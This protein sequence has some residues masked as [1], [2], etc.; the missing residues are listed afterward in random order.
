M[1]AKGNRIAII[2]G[3]RTPFLRAGTGFNDMMGWELGRHAV[4]GLVAKTGI[5]GNNVGHVIFGTVAVDVATTNVAREILLGAGLPDSIP[6]HTCTVAC[7]SA[8]MAI[9]SGI[10]LIETGQVDS[11]IAGGVEFMSDLDIRISKKY[12]RFI[13][14]MTLFKRPK[15]LGGK[16]KLLKKMRPSDFIVPQRPA[17]NEFATNHSMGDNAE[18][19]AK[20][21]GI[22]REQQDEYAAMSHQRSARAIEEGALRHEVTPV[23][24]PGSG[25]AVAVDNGP[26]K[27][28]T[29]ERLARL[30]PAFDRRYGSVTAGNSSFLTDGASAVLLM[31]EKK[32][33]SLGLKPKAYVKSYAYTAQDLW[34]ELLLGPSIAI[35]KVLGQARLTLKDIG[36]LEIHEAFG[37]QML[38]VIKTLG[39]SKFA[40]ERLGLT[41][42]VGDIDINR[43]NVYGG[44]LSIGHPFGATGGRLVTT[45]ANRLNEEKT[46][47]GLVAAC[48]GGAVGHAMILE[49]AR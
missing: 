31:S 32:A 41:K 20:R 38:A 26:R 6:A 7:V 24:P 29:K 5:S 8:N 39:S 45:C 16:L 17:I 13:L 1:P 15:T 14:D 43:L 35:P 47:F 44:S 10:N 37:A 19:L 22:T 27:D 48:A 30:K 36:V 34:T 11:V 3:I 12:R 33:K 23:V 42:K 25:R 46:K 40:K 28:T 2:D 21:L 18:L 49:N 4:K 9:T